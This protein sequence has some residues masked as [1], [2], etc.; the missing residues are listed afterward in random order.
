VHLAKTNSLKQA[1]NIPYIY[2]LIFKNLGN[3][4]LS[5]IFYIVV[6]IIYSIATLLIV[7][8]PF[9]LVTTYV[10]GQYIFT[11]FYMEATEIK[12]Q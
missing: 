6:S 8:Y 1:M 10:A 9:M 3:F 12:E 11:I 7:T 4:T 2:S 5:I